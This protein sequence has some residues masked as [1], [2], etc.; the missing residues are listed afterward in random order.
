[1]AC[2]K[3]IAM[4]MWD[5]YIKQV[6]VLKRKEGM[7]HDDFRK[8][9]LEHH[10][11]L[12]LESLPAIEKYVIN[13]IRQGKRGADYDAV[14]EIFW[15]DFETFVGLTDTYQKKVAHDEDNF[16]EPVKSQIVDLLKKPVENVDS[17]NIL[18]KLL[19][20]AQYCSFT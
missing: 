6:F 13:F 17:E 8:Y 14:T 12:V 16:D 5:P 19:R 18:S 1:L 9:Y 7:S 20:R 11:P 10:A 3:A 4:D 15:S 2:I